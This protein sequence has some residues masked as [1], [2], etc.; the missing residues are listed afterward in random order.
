VVIGGNCVIF[1]SGFGG[2]TTC[3]LIAP[4]K[5]PP[6]PVMR[7]VITIA[8]AVRRQLDELTAATRLVCSGIDSALCIKS[9]TIITSI[10]GVPIN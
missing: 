10:A 4:N 3:L 9:E 6:V 5:Y 1:I 7:A 2:K 8:I